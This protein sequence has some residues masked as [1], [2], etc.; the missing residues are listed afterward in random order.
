[1]V[2]GVH[3]TPD[4]AVRNAMP[5]GRTEN[6][7]ARQRAKAVRN[8]VTTDTDRAPYARDPDVQLMLRVKAG[9]HDAFCQL[10]S[11]HQERVVNNLRRQVR[12]SHMAEDLAQEVFLRIYGARKRYQPTAKFSTWLFRITSNLV[13]NSRRNLGRRREVPLALWDSDQ[14]GSSPAGRRLVQEPAERPETRLEEAETRNLVRSAIGRLGQRQQRA[15]VLQQFERKSCA[16]IGKAMHITPVA[17]KSLLSRA[18]ENLRTE[19]EPHL[20]ALA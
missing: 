11:A 7:T 6:P 20:G 2:C 14:N 17:V 5:R 9:D 16:E 13:S 12:D 8:V 1:M 10:V 4:R 3:K 15:V 18:R 19:L